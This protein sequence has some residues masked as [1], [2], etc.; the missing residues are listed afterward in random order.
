MSGSNDVLAQLLLQQSRQQGRRQSASSRLAEQMMAGL[1]N[2]TPVYSTG[3]TLARAG[4]GLLAGLMAQRAESQDQAREDEQMQRLQDRTDKRDYLDGQGAADFRIRMSGEAPGRPAAAPSSQGGTWLDRLE[5]AES[6]GNTSARNPRSSAGGN[7]QFIDD[8][9]RAFARANPAQFEGMDDAAILASRFDPQRGRQLGRQAAEWYAGE[10]ARIL[11]EQ[12]LPNG[13]AEQALAHRFGPAGAAAMLRATPDTPIGTA[14]PDGARVLMANPDLRG[15]SVGEFLTNNSARYGGQGQPAPRPAGTQYAGRPTATD[16]S[17]PGPAAPPAGPAAQRQPDFMALYLEA[18]SSRNPQIRAMAPGLLAQANRADAQANR[19]PV[20]VSPG[21]SM[22]DPNTGRVIYTAPRAPESESSSRG[23]IPEGMR[24]N[25]AGTLEEIPG[26][27]QRPQ[28]PD[29]TERLLRASGYTP[30]TPEY[31]AQARILLQRR[32]QPPQTN[33]NVSPETSLMRADSDTLKAINEG[34]GQA[35][36]LIS[37]L[38]RTERAVRAVPEGQAARFLPAVGQTLASFGVQV[39]GTSEAEILNALTGQLA[40]LQRIPGSGATTDYEMR[41]FLQAVPRLGNTRDG[42]L[43]LLDMG[44]RLARRRIEEAA[45]W[46]RYVGQPDLMERLDALPPV[47]GDSDME[48]LMSGP[49]AR[50][51]PLSAP[52]RPPGMIDRARN[53][54]NASGT[55]QLPPG[56]EVVQ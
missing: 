26:Y 41:L 20:T 49:A 23:P 35:R 53:R 52:P 54:G 37:L 8:T 22:V 25:S 3:A 40:G 44:R 43:A 30:G 24:L 17:A 5:T 6:S 38:D 19:P 51:A 7:F 47:F 34:Q 36:A 50:A 13:P 21:A 9:W 15:V 12:G 16:A 45:I 10:N 33:V 31:E 4:S 1:N 55:P 14:V 11:G 46:R 29:D 18:S 39:P 48:V 27:R 42:N 32:G 56:F 2:P 28:Q